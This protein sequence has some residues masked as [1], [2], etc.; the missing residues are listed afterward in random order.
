MITY[1]KQE[2]KLRE[3]RSEACL[4]DVVDY[5][6]NLFAVL[7][8]VIHIVPTVGEAHSAPAYSKNKLEFRVI[9]DIQEKTYAHDLPECEC[10][11]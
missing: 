8:I 9:G 4:K 2:R 3:Q 5:S 10:F 1:S 7:L 6:K 11:W